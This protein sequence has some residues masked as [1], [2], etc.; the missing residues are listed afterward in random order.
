MNLS[1]IKLVS[2]FI[3]NSKLLLPVI[4]SRKY[5][6]HSNKGNELITI[7]IETYNLKD[8]HHIKDTVLY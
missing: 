8:L 4:I 1:L 6:C 3:G 2:L 7:D 5:E